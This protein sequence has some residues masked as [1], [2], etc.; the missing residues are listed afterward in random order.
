MQHGAQDDSLSEVTHTD[1][2]M[3]HREYANS[4]QTKQWQDSNP[5]AGGK[6]LPAVSP[7]HNFKNAFSHYYTWKIHFLL[8][9]MR[10]IVEC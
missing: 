4:A 5:S 2:H 6:I 8:Y 3:T 7:F 1:M 10:Y 9:I